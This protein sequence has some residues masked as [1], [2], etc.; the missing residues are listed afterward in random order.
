M[1]EY[2]R[3]AVPERD[4]LWKRGPESRADAGL[5]K[6]G[7]R[8]GDAVMCPKCEGSGVVKGREMHWYQ[9]RT[10]GAGQLIDAPVK[11]PTCGGEGLDPR[12][13]Q[14]GG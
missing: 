6:F 8:I 3:V 2:E 10:Y 14:G 1:A 13:G 5:R 4:S 7:P 11:C 9:G 12:G